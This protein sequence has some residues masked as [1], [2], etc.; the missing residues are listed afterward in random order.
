MN[1]KKRASPANATPCEVVVARLENVKRSGSGFTARC[2]AHEDQHNSLSVS[3]GVDGRA[4]LNCFVGCQVSTIVASIGLSLADL[5]PHQ[6]RQDGMAPSQQCT[7]ATVTLTEYA[8]A[9]KLPVDFLR[10]LGLSDISYQGQ[11]AIRIPY[12]DHGGGEIAVRIRTALEKSAEGD[13]RFRWRKGSKPRLYGLWRKLATDYAILCEG[14]SDCHTLWF[15]GFSALGFPGATNWNEER[16]ASQLEGVVTIYV[17]IEPDNGGEAVRTWL[18]KSKIACRAKLLTLDGFKDPSALYLDDPPRFPARLRQVMERAIPVSRA[19]A[20]QT[21]S[22]KAAAWA[23]CKHLASSVNGLERFEET[24]RARGVVGEERTAKLL[25][26]ALTSR[27]LERPVSVAIKGPSS[28]GK[29]FL[30]E[31]V[32]SFFPASAV[33]CLS[34]RPCTVA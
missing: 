12:F 25:Y 27:F 24:L 23:H 33:Y 18:A 32:L 30:T 22:E 6:S 7:T 15:H 13:N 1:R 3:E 10:S 11:P 8:A 28:G 29:S 16:D 14:E 17:V 34:H 2:P 26:L 4:L 31:Q 5:F 9:K 19:L 21:A 20:E